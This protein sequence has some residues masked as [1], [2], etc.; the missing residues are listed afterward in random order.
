MTDSVILETT[1]STNTV[2]KEMAQN[3]APEGKSV[4]A[5]SQSGGRGRMGRSFFSPENS[6]LY[7]SILLRP[8]F[9]SEELKFLTP[10][11]AVAVSE[12]IEK[13]SGEKTEIKWVND[14]YKN[15]RKICGIL[16]EGAF[17]DD[18]ISYAIVGIGVNIE[19]PENGFPEEIKNIAGAIFEKA[20]ENA[21][22]TLHDEIYK[23]IFKYYNNFREKKFI[24][25]Y[26]RR[27]TFLSGKEITVTDGDNVFK[28]TAHT[29]DRECR[30]EVTTSEGVK[31][32]I[33]S[34]DV[35]IKIGM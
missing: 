4:A 26:I 14:I 9:D 24:D 6:G 13:I 1:T 12:A 22:M 16:T 25:E 17:S 8:S 31:K 5:K 33:Y 32:H 27:C 29:V 2:L 23:N 35:S 34:G 15:G 28:A 21:F 10:M 30:L 18:K 20:P 11:A 3:G 19:A 7:M